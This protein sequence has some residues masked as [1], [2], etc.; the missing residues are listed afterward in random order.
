MNRTA[1]PLVS[2]IAAVPLLLVVPEARGDSSRDS[3]TESYRLHAS[4]DLSG[5]IR[6]MGD[7]VARH[8]QDYFRHLRLAYLQLTNGDYA[9]A[10]MTY[11][12]ASEMNRTAIEPLLGEQQALV[13]AGRYAEA[14][15]VGRMALRIDPKSYLAQS[16]LAWSLLMLKKYGEAADRYG[17]VIELYPADVDMHLGYAEALLGAG[18][19]S[20]AAAAF[21]Q[22]LDMVPG[23]K[24]AAAGLAACQ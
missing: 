4:G 24:D 2:A 17:D 1:L 12:E 14:E 23:H 8:P 19:K 20:Q 22:V 10:A 18:R 11:G 3:L 15:R 21:Q 13:N 9:K 5:A 16:R 6:A 7:A